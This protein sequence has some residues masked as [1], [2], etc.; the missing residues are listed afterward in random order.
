VIDATSDQHGR[1]QRSRPGVPD[2][3]RTTSAAP[4][5]AISCAWVCPRRQPMQLTGHRTRSV[6]DRYDIV[7]EQ[8]LRDAVGKLAVERSGQFRDSGRKNAVS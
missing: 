8:D 2:V 6:F 3:S 7:N 1:R 5:S 4:R